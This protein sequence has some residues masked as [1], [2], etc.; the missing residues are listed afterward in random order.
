MPWDPAAAGVAWRSTG[1]AVTPTFLW[2]GPGDSH[3]L[4]VGTDRSRQYVVDVGPSG[5]L[6][7]D[8]WDVVRVLAYGFN[9]LAARETLRYQRQHVWRVSRM[10]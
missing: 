7:Q 1:V 4:V 9:D 2:Q 8:P 6:A 3:W 5:A 10:R